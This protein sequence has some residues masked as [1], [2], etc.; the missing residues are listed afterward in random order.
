MRSIFKQNLKIL[1]LGT[2]FGSFVPTM[3]ETCLERER[4]VQRHRW[5]NL[6]PKS[7]GKTYKLDKVLSYSEED[8]VFMD[9]PLEVTHSKHRDLDIFSPFYRPNTVDPQFVDRHWYGFKQNSKVCAEQS[10]HRAIC[11]KWQ[12][13]NDENSYSRKCLYKPM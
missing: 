12:K 9:G 11:E 10:P 4:S 6:I 13:W 8:S 3:A 7:R 2:T 1:L 5:E